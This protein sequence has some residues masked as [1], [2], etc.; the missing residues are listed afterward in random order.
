M[1]KNNNSPRLARWL[2]HRMTSY[3]NDHSIS[4]DVEEVYYQV[5]EERGVISAY[6]WYWHQCLISLGKY[7][8]AKIKGRSAMF[9]NYLK[10]AFRNMWRNKGF[11]LLNAAGLSTGLACLVFIYLW[12][13]SELSYD[14]FHENSD[15][16]YSVI[17]SIEGKWTYDCPWALGQNIMDNYPEVTGFTRV[18]NIQPV[19][20]AGEKVVYRDAIMVDDDFFNMFTFPLVSGDP[21][22]VF[23]SRSSA[24][25]TTETAEYLFGNIDPVGKTILLNNSLELTVT[26][27]VEDPPSYSTIAYDI[28][29][30]LKIL[31]DDRLRSWG[32]GI[33]TYV[34]L[35]ENSTAGE[36]SEKISQ[37]VNRQ[38]FMQNR[39]VPVNIH[40]YGMK[41]LHALNEMGQIKYIYMFSAIAVLIMLIACVNFMNMTTARSGARVREI[42]MRKVSG[43]V[44]SD[45][46]L[47]FL[48]EPVILAFAG[49]GIALFAVKLLLPEFNSLT[50][51]NISFD[52]TDNYLNLLFLAGI[53]FITGIISGSYPAFLISKFRPVDIMKNMSRTGSGGILLRR[54]LIVLQ[55]AASVILIVSALVIYNQMVFIRELDIGLDRDNIMVMRINSDLRQ[56]LNPVK[57]EL[58]QLNNVINVTSASN[59]PINVNNYNPVYWEGGS[60]DNYTGMF[61]V[62]IDHDYFDTFGIEFTHGRKFNREFSTD[63]NN[64][65]INEEALKLTRLRSPIGKMF[66]MWENEGQIVGVIK[67]FLPKSLYNDIFPIAFTMSPAFNHT[68]L[69]VKIDGNDISGTLDSIESTIVKFSP[70]FPFDYSFLD[71]RFQ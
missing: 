56:S 32:Y 69:F 30:P 44:R 67:N 28:V 14:G 57:E 8:I 5:R 31:G 27:I 23:E 38:N 24:V 11:T 58:K 68:F 26:G 15:N 60:P 63:V 10:T 39:D 48:G 7:L 3:Q 35:A 21:V 34:M 6:I 29:I 41:H 37:I 64:Y 70:G 36:F 46:I 55:F 59:L 50:G 47:Q 16:L 49:L 12:I 13:S 1:Q 62:D 20:K 22:A 51:K 54:L 4:G 33:D 40:P 65:I 25:L 53:A 61:F 18:R 17:T 19:I 2:F 52:I 43:A 42:G 71:D 9:E 45:I 66:S